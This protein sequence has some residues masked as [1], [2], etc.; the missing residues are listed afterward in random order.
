MK[1]RRSL[2]LSL[3]ALPL[4]CAAGE[5]TFPQ[6]IERPEWSRFFA[7]AQALGSI[8]ILDKR[9][10]ASTTWVHGLSRA[11]RR[12]T[13]ASTF[14]IA[15]SL[16]ALDAGL[17]KDEFQVISWD[18][19]KRT[20]QIWNRDQTLRSA[21]RNSVVWVYQRFASELGPQRESA[22]MR[23]IN[24]GNASTAGEAPFWVEGDLSI[25]CVEQIDFLRRLYD[26][27]LPFAV[28][29]QRLVKDVMVV[30]AGRDWILRAKTGWSGKI[31]RWVGWVE[32]P[33][34]PVFFALNIDTPGRLEDL[35]KRE[36]V[37]R[38]V[39]RSINALPPA[40]S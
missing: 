3:G 24:Y 6:P 20:P 13:P 18:G 33:S 30:E 8:L 37:T 4:V 9:E 21:M 25:S 10:G 32:W 40:A 15:H 31:G 16:F 29:H 2:V 5:S 34:G 38:A 19:V 22:Y 7:E 12:H 23:T 11:Q 36:A 35:P 14:K 17:I 1:T 26:N 39:L 27:Q 28:Q